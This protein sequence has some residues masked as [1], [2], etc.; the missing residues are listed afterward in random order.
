MNLEVG[1]SSSKFDEV[2]TTAVEGGIN[3]WCDGVI[4]RDDG[5]YRLKVDGDW[6]TLNVNVVRRGLGLLASSYPY[7]FMEVVDGVY[8]SEA[9]DMAVQL[10]LFEDVI[11]G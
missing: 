7:Q 10:G 6:H 8:D 11:Y 9:A 3:Y 1:I 2:L 4:S 5:S